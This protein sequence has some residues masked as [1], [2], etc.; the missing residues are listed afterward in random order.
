MP[1]CPIDVRRLFIVVCFSAVSYQ[2]FSQEKLADSKELIE[3]GIKLYEEQRY[4]DAV[5]IFLQVPEGDTNYTS[6]KYETALAYLA[7]SAYEQAKI[8]ALEGLELQDASPRDFLLIIGHAYDYLGKRDSAIAVYRELAKNNPT[9][10][11]PI[12][13]EG[14]VYFQQQ[15]YEEA[16]ALFQR[17]LMINPYHFRSHLMLGTCYYLQGRLTEAFIALEV[18]LLTS[19]NI[20]VARSSITLLDQLTKQA[21]EARKAYEAKEEHHRHEVYDDIDQIINAKLALNK[22]Y[23]IESVLNDDNIIRVAHVIMEKL[24][25]EPKDDNF[26]MQYYVPMLK[27][28]YDRKLFDPYM[29]LLFS[30]YNIEAVE[31]Y[32]K[33]QQKDVTEVKDLVFPYMSKILATRVLPYAERER[34]KEQYLLD[35]PSNVYISGSFATE[36]GKT[37]IA[38][39]YAKLY[40]NGKLAAEGNYNS[41]GKKTGPWKYFHPDGS[42]KLTEN[43]QDGKITGELKRYR[44]NGQPAYYERYNNKEETVEE[45][46]YTYNGILSK[47]TVIKDNKEKTT[48][49]YHRNGQKNLTLLFNDEKIIDGNYTDY[50]KNGKVSRVMQ[51][52]DGKLNGSYKDH[53][54]NGQLKEDGTFKNGNRHG[55]FKNYYENGKLYTLLNYKDG[56]LDGPYEEY[57]ELGELISKVNYKDG[58]RHGS[59][60]D[61]E[62]GRQYGSIEYKDGSPVAYKFT[63]AEGKVVGEQ[64]EGKLSMLRVFYANGA[65]RSEIPMRNGMFEGEAKYFYSTGALKEQ[66]TYHDGLADGMSTEYYR[67]GKIS[68]KTTMVKGEKTGPYSSYYANGQL[69]TKGWLIEASKEGQWYTYSSNGKP[70]DEIFYIDN[71]VNGPYKQY[72]V[73]GELDYIDYYDRDMLVGV[74]QY[75]S[76]GKLIL[77]ERFPGGNGSYK[78]VYANGEKYF[79]CELK[80]GIYQGKFAKYYPGNKVSET[81][82]YTYGLRDSTSTSYFPNGRTSAKGKYSKDNREGLWQ[83]FTSDGLLARETEYEGGEEEGKDRIYVNGELHTEYNMHNDNM[84][85]DQVYY[86]EKN[87]VACVLKYKN[88][89]LAGYT[90]MDKEGKLMPMIPIKNGTAQFTTFYQNGTKATEFNFV[91][92]RLAGKQVRYYS[93]GQ[94]AEERSIENSDY[95]GPYKRYYEEGKLMYE[96]FYKDNLLVGE[97]RHYGKDGAVRTNNYFYDK[98]HGMQQYKDLST[99]NTTSIYYHYGRPVFVKN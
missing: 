94:I 44:L 46:S 25:Y 32:L 15:K 41:S 61:F 74:K 5:K 6:A 67:N 83:Y 18:S 54:D 53:F 89:D 63:D 98:L 16:I 97:E 65:K 90:Y 81:G 84:E 86:G 3:N 42:V 29:L 95:N 70:Y 19:N 22:G 31:K 36:K 52:A 96:A 91:E 77:S 43:Y 60:V 69:K 62:D 47:V 58:K 34:A 57:N 50:H 2:S 28:V 21:D 59:D 48:T 49:S 24:K 75:D 27:E 78:L 8:T 85:G 93:N 73:N 4:K 51:I 1:F 10:H 68:S 12:F 76:T 23:K 88:K 99:G 11:Q 17:S 64:K 66:L 20:N 14:V 72:N 37:T 13:E 80:N 82:F 79:E 92:G 71:E 55:Q 7:D 45:K 38:A 26:V 40:Q 30:G 56:E 9:D 35:Q 39:G 87:K 33:K